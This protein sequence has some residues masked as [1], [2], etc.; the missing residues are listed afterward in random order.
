[1]TTVDMRFG[2]RVKIECCSV[3]VNFCIFGYLMKRF[4]IL[5]FMTFFPY[6]PRGVDVFNFHNCLILT[7]FTKMSLLACLFPA[8]P[9]ALLFNPFKAVPIKF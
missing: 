8:R 5:N 6:N 1:M 2:P 7:G 9:N 3:G 4:E